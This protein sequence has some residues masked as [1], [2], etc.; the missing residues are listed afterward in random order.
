MIDAPRR[1]RS[2]GEN[3][4]IVHAILAAGNRP[5]SAYDIADRASG[6]VGRIAPAQIY[7]TLARLVRQG[8]AL[9]IEMLGAYV[10]CVG[11]VD[12]CLVCV[13]CRTVEVIDDTALANV[14]HGHAD[15]RDFT[16]VA[17]PVEAAGR[18]RECRAGTG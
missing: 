15:R 1:R 2:S 6:I 16:V 8:R 3:D 5:L 7:R 13:D 4:D 18:C 9:R 17:T 12:A 11:K 10:R 14:I